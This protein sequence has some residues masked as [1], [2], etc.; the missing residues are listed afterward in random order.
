MGKT[1]RNP[2]KGKKATILRK[3]G[4]QS[5][6]TKLGGQYD[7]VVVNNLCEKDR[8]RFNGGGGGV[9]T[10]TCP[11]WAFPRVKYLQFVQEWQ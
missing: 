5:N 3:W 11:Y 9:K 6:L 10:V 8:T 7:P 4:L 2:A 1:I